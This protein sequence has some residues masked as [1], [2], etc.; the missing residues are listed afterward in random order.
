MRRINLLIII[1]V[2]MS[3]SCGDLSNVPTH[4]GDGDLTITPPGSTPG[5]PAVTVVASPASIALGGTSTIT[6]TVLDSDGALVPDGTSVSFSLSAPAM[7]SI[8]AATA[9]TTNG[10]AAVTFTAATTPGSVTV[11]ATFGTTSNTAIISISTQAGSLTLTASQ[12]ILTVLGSSSISATVLDTV[13]ANMPDGTVVSYSLSSDILGTINPQSTISGG[14]AI[15]TFKA[16]NIPG[17]VTVT[18]TSGSVSNTVDIVINAPDTGSIEYESASPTVIGLSGSGN[19]ETSLVTYLVNDVNGNPVVDGIAVDFVMEGPSGGRLPSAGGEYIGD[20]N[21]GTPTMAS[22]STVNG[23]ASVYVNSGKVAGIVT[24]TASVPGTGIDP[25]DSAPIS[26]GGGLPNNTHLTIATSRWNLE[27]LD[28]V[29][30]QADISVALADRFGN[31]N[32]LKGTSVSFMTESGA[33]NTGNTTNPSTTIVDADGTASVVFRTQSPVPA[34]PDHPEGKDVIPLG[35][36]G[37]AGC[38]DS[39]N[40][41]SWKQINKGADWES[42]LQEYVDFTYNIFTTR[43]PRDGWANIIVSTKGEEGFDDT[44]GNGVYDD[45]IDTFFDTPE[46]P[47]IDLN[48]DK[49]HNDG[50]GVGADPFEIYTDVNNN[51]TYDDINGEWDDNK[52]IFKDITLLITGAPFYR[53]TNPT[54]FDIGDPVAPPAG[55][56]W[57]T[58]QSFTLLVA[59]KNLNPLIGG[60]EVSISASSG[61]LTGETTYTFPDLFIAGP[62]ELSFTLSDDDPTDT[63]PPKAASIDIVITYKDNE[64]S[65]SIPGNVD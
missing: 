34:S 50:V 38:G 40:G 48:D 57:P 44:N 43:H 46:E 29:N 14:T 4:G 28:Y 58:S 24:I 18:A 23:A 53:V 55:K 16:A 31:Y 62:V 61:E 54:S 59:D 52:T 63:D 27:G 36:G 8:D 3:F 49:M 51:G 1:L 20:M 2:F 25:S 5:Q 11:T 32:I 56:G 10:I 47:F 41:S 12:P 13:S 30:V 60:T 45:G 26:I 64:Y 9:N 19:T 17:T 65:F 39:T 15:A 42:C 35:G 33:I 6:A 7:G 21:D 22:T 37:A